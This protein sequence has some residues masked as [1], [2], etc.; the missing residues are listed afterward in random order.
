L[1]R[2]RF[3]V[4]QL[5]H[6]AVDDYSRFT[7]LFLINSKSYT[8]VILKDFINKVQNVFSSTIKTLRTDNGC[9]YIN[10]PVQSMLSEFGIQHQ[11]SYVYT[12]QQNEVVERRHRTILEM[13]RSIRFQSAMPLKFWGDCVSTAVYLLNRLPSKVIEYKTPYEMLY[14]HPPNV[15]HLK[16]FGCLGYASTPRALDKF[17]SRAIPVVFI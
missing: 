13:A 1:N 15:N 4:T 5:N 2:T 6:H 11:T 7:W 10:H 3:S 9:E 14:M 17:A 8:I 16:V 12:P